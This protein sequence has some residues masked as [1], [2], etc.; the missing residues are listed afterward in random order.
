[1]QEN[2]NARILNCEDVL[3]FHCTALQRRRSWLRLFLG[4]AG[5]SLAKG[6][7]NAW[8][9][10]GRGEVVGGEVRGRGRG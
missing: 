7:E 9:G 8:A 10:G 1:M 2:T 5:S 4:V 6:G 3:S